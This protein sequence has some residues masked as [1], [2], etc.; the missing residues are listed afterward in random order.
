MAQISQI[1]VCT[2]RAHRNLIRILAVGAQKK[3]LAWLLARR[4]VVVKT[5]AIPTFA[6]VAL[7]SAQK[8]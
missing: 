8:A 2:V 6:F 1:L 5:P 3:P 7:S 4:G